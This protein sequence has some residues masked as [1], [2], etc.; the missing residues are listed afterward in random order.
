MLYKIVFIECLSILVI[1]SEQV[2]RNLF[3]MI[4]H[5]LFKLLRKY[6]IQI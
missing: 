3:L 2:P 1:L 5:L 4:L 6:V